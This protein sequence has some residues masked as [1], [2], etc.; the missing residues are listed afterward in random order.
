[1]ISIDL[2]DSVN[3]FDMFLDTGSILSFLT[4]DELCCTASRVKFTNDLVSKLISPTF[5]E[6][7]EYDKIKLLKSIRLSTKDKL[8][9][10]VKLFENILNELNIPIL[11]TFFNSIKVHLQQT[12]VNIARKSSAKRVNLYQYNAR[13]KDTFS[14][15]EFKSKPDNW[16]P[17]TELESLFLN[18]VSEGNN[19][20]LEEILQSNPHFNIY[21]EDN[22]QRNAILIACEKGN[23]STVKLLYD[24]GFN[25]NRASSEGFY[26]IHVAAYYNMFEIFKFLVLKNAKI[27]I[28]IE[29]CIKLIDFAVIGNAFDVFKYLTNEVNMQIDRASIQ[30]AANTCSRDIFDLIFTKCNES[31]ELLKKISPTLFLLALHN[32]NID[33]LDYLIDEQGVDLNAQD[34]TGKTPLM[35]AIENKQI[36]VV[37]YLI[38]KGADVY[39]RIKF[40][41]VKDALYFAVKVGNIEIL[42]ELFLAGAEI[43][44]YNRLIEVAEENNNLEMVHYLEANR[45]N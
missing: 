14:F 23:L 12:R 16:N 42:L 13:K 30:L 10:N 43:D 37:K 41:D 40:D 32:S 2:H 18:Y 44:N 4:L 5:D 24:H 38:Q 22:D 29:P 45:N 35:I 17:P 19:Q 34:E 25:V 36:E 33:A 8:H 3:R 9:E 20:Q 26:A 15:G 27:D 1:M 39:I 31:T 28:I 21:C 11:T 7:N 6:C